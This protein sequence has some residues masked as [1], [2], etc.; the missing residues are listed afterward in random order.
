L[1]SVQEWLCTKVLMNTEGETG[2]RPW[3]YLI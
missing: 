1:I 3:R 2:R